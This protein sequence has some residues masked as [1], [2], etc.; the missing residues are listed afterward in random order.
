MRFCMKLPK[1]C[2]MSEDDAVEDDD[3]LEESAVLLVVVSVLTP[4]PIW[5]RAWKIAL[6]KSPPG[7]GPGGGDISVLLLLVVFCVWSTSLC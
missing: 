2:A 3:E 4:A 1:A 6:R 5:V 7:G